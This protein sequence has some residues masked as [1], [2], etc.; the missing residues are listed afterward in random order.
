MLE[1]YLG[2][3]KMLPL[4]WNDLS[5]GA[6]TIIALACLAGNAFTQDLSGESKS[7]LLE[8]LTPE[9]KALLVRAKER[10]IFSVQGTHQAFDA[11]GRMLCVFVEVAP[12]Q[13]VRFADPN[14]TR[15]T[16]RFLE[17]FEQLCRYSL[18]VHQ[19]DHEFALTS[20][21]F[22]IAEAIDSSSVAKLLA[23]GVDPNRA[24]W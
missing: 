9:A 23:L 24:E 19:A 3:Q 2:E 17:G 4:A 6:P 22:E 10:G 1:R 8:T 13:Q 5:R 21:G 15:Q 11:I 18:V 12:D 7:Q 20:A 16:I 14:S